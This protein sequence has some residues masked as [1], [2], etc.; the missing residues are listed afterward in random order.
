MLGQGDCE[1]VG[2]VGCRKRV[3]VRES[4]W[5]GDGW[6]R[7]WLEAKNALDLRMRLRSGESRSG[8]EG[9]AWREGTGIEP[10]G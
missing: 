6:V 5:L 4:A 3:L 1:E 10:I 7:T 2:A 9:R 8:V